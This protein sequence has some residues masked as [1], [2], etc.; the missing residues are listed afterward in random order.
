MW[1]NTLRTLVI[2]PGD[3]KD[4]LSI[5]Y[6]LLCYNAIWD[7]LEILNIQSPLPGLH[8]LYQNPGNIT[9]THTGTRDPR[10]DNTHYPLNPFK[11]NQK[12]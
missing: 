7:R 2:L 11:P 10:E 8:T 6:R 4:K 5:L 3:K 1:D 9:E 12:P